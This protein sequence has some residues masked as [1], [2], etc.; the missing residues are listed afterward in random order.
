MLEKDKSRGENLRDSFNARIRRK[1]LKTV[2]LV[3]LLNKF[4]KNRKLRKKL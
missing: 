4:R 3:K 2:R 1:K